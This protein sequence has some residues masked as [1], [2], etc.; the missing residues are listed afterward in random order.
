MRIEL[1]QGGFVETIKM[2]QLFK[3]NTPVRTR[4]SMMMPTTRPMTKGM[5][6]PYTGHEFEKCEGSW[7]THADVR[8][9]VPNTEEAEETKE[10]EEPAHDCERNLES[11]MRNGG[12]DAL[13]PNTKLSSFGAW[14]W[15]C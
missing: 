5:A 15:Y 1:I 6:Q 3:A 11:V 4:M 14:W 7:G 8:A 13:Q 10:T 9:V 12:D 2:L